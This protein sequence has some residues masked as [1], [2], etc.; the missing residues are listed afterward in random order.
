VSVIDCPVCGRP[1]NAEATR[2]PECGANPRLSATEARAEVI[3]RHATT[4]QRPPKPSLRGWS[5]RRR[6]LVAIPG[7]LLP[8]AFAIMG[9]IAFVWGW[10]F[11]FSLPGA[12]R[13]NGDPIS[14][15]AGMT[16]GVVLILIALVLA[17]LAVGAVYSRRLDTSLGVTLL[18]VSLGVLG[19]VVWAVASVSLGWW[20]VWACLPFAYVPALIGVRLL[21]Q[22]SAGRPSRLASAPGTARP[23]SAST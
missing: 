5:R 11:Y 12:E 23:T 9:V 10:R 1:V 3:T 20:S 16:L 2:C 19:L 17:A 22:S 6:V 7:L 18:V 21:W 13:G 8:A 4:A 15:G 14:N